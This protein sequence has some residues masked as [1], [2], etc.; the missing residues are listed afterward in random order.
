[1]A[2]RNEPLDRVKSRRDAG[3]AAIVAA[4]PYISGWESA[5]TGAGTS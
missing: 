5:S 4:I 2:D 1:M 3:I